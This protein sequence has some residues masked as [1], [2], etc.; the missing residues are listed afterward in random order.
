M[1]LKDYFESIVRDDYQRYDFDDFLK[2]VN[3]KYTVP[4]IH[5]AGSNGKGSTANYLA[6]IYKNHGL[7][8][9]LF[10]SPYLNEINEMISING[11]LISDEEIFNY[12]NTN[13]KLFNKY[14]LSS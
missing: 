13:E 2:K 7:K 10:T 6:N 1:N 5:I 3:F 12:I 14:S 8:V 11:K 4:S 9:G